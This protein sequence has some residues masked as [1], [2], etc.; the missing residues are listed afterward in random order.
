MDIPEA[1]PQQGL[2]QRAGSPLLPCFSRSYCNSHV[3][4]GTIFAPEVRVDLTDEN[5][6]AVAQR[7]ER[8]SQDHTWM[9]HKPEHICEGHH[10]ETGEFHRP[11]LHSSV[12]YPSV[13]QALTGFLHTY[14]RR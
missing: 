10:G 1:R 8:K 5:P 11:F 4:F 9:L 6:A 7:G 12:D 13:F 3:L 14:M 2:L